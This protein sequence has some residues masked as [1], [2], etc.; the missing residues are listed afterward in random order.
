MRR[1]RPHGVDGGVNGMR[2]KKESSGAVH[3]E[4][5]PLRPSC[6]EFLSH[7]KVVITCVA[8]IL[9]Q[10]DSLL[11]IGTLASVLIIRFI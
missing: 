7:A 3:R 4:S 8:G 6:S 9:P 11:V 5:F 1:A 2:I 10:D